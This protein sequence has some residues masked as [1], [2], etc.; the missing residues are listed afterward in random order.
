MS[1]MK[2]KLEFEVEG[3]RPDQLR[4]EAM[5]VCQRIA[6]NLGSNGAPLETVLRDRR[7]AKVGMAEYDF[8][9]ASEQ[10]ASEL[11]VAKARQAAMDAEARRESRQFMEEAE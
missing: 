11:E 9:A 1:T 10:R 2:V 7:G 3:E 5:D 6:F 4:A 8:D